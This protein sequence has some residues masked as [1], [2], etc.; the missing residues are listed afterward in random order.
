MFQLFDPFR[1]YDANRQ[2]YSFTVERHTETDNLHAGVR[3]RFAD[4]H[5]PDGGIDNSVLGFSL[6]SV[7]NR[8]ILHT[9]RFADG[10]FETAFCVTF[11]KE[12]DPEFTVYVRYD[13]TTRTGEGVRLH[14]GLNGVLTAS[15]V[16][17]QGSSAE[18]MDTQST[19]FALTDSEF[20]PLSITI[21]PEQVSCRV[22]GAEFVFS[23]TK[24]R[25]RLAIERGNFIGELILKQIGF[26]SPEEFASRSILPATTAEIPMIN[27]GSIPYRFT[28]Q[29]DEI[30]GE[31]YLRCGLDGGTKTR[32]VNK[33]N[34][35]GQYV[36]EIDWMDDPYVGICTGGKDQRFELSLG[37][38]GFVDPNNYWDCLAPY[39]GDTELP[40]EGC[41]R[42]NMPH[43]DE[44]SAILFG[45][46]KLRC[47]NY[48]AQ[49]G[50]REFRFAPDGR[51]LYH[52]EAPDGRDI[53]NLY[54]PFD[55]YAVTAI[56]ADCCR[57]VEVVEHFKYNHYFEISE[58]IRFT[59]EFATT[60]DSD[61]FSA[62]AVLWNAYETEKLAQCITDLT[63][64]CR[65]FDRFPCVNGYHV[66][67]ADAAF[68]PLPVGVY[69]VEF[70]ILYGG[71]EYHRVSH[72]FEVFD[73]N[74]E[75][76]PA[77]A[78]GLP[79]VFS[80]PNEH[81]WLEHNSF[82]PWSPARS[83]DVEHYIACVTDTP[84]E[85]EA[86]RT[87]E[88][89]PMFKREWFAWVGPRTCNDFRSER[90]H[91][92][93]QHA[94]YTYY[95]MDSGIE[96][97]LGACSIFPFRPDLWE[98]SRMRN[99]F[100]KK[101]LKEFFAAHPEAAETLDYT[102]SDKTMP[103]DVFDR[104]MSR[105][106]QEWKALVVERTT[107]IF[108]T[109]NQELAALNPRIR[110]AMYGPVSTYVTPNLT[111]KTLP[112]FGLPCD[113]RLTDTVYTG[114]AILEDYP[115]SCSYQ[116]WRGAFLL[117]TLLPHT[118][119]L[120]IYPE[121]YSGGMGG[122][123]DGAVKFAHAPMGKYDL[124]AH[125]N[126]SHAY[127]FVYNTAHLTADGFRYWDTY[128][129]HRSD[130]SSAYM[131][132][133]GAAWGHVVRSKPV[134][135]LRTMAFAVD[136]A[137][138]DDVFRSFALD[139]GRRHVMYNIS[140]AGCGLLHECSRT[141]GLPNG[142]G[143]R[144]RDFA[145]LNRDNCDILVLPS[146][147]DAAPETLEE[148]RRLYHAGVN[149]VAV[150][151]VSGLEDLFGVKSCPAHAR[152]TE[153]HCNEKTEYVYNM[154]ADFR[155]A[156]CSAQ[157]LLTSNNGLPAVLATER[158]LLINTD[159][160]NLGCEDIG[161]TCVCSAP[162]F[163]GELLPQLLQQELNRL[164]RPLAQGGD[165]TGVT[166]FETA[167]GRT[168]LMVTDYAPFD[169]IP[170]T[171]REVAVRLNLDVADVRSDRPLF[172]GRKNGTVRE[173]RLR[174]KSHETA[175]VELKLK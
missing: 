99:P 24:G 155:Y 76:N 165:R 98:Y 13:E 72:T 167:D 57:R 170:R 59:L 37:T 74:S 39:F 4:G 92:V 26:V 101:L 148:I 95:G 31:Y 97:W 121:Q 2:P 53:C 173:I 20:V 84:I 83:C 174:L 152:V 164:S 105:Y 107:D 169:N 133:E 62:E 158:T 108:R 109:Q 162:H 131:R 171:E 43:V 136:Y 77:L 144:M 12:I 23:L 52:G 11:L 71:Q 137:D 159:V 47:R 147:A 128:G 69:Q 8:H 130:R 58:Q 146:L 163:V 30:D 21:A 106:H 66:L 51:L 117:M 118:P 42:L 81:K 91:I 149:L 16:R 36:A 14:F 102:P 29:L 10:L 140:E 119:G 114:F 40:L 126:A 161:K 54:S 85:A 156:P 79:Y 15:L 88:L 70:R 160:N 123:I 3:P 145:L 175:F 50:A 168:E 68:A 1:S 86:R 90:H 27:G 139:T 32:P 166:L 138:S 134:R 73:R 56:P 143:V 122:C 64:G 112:L 48:S 19:A 25:G 150:S 63:E 17:L 96:D 103:V 65:E 110:R 34:R 22:G 5:S 142:F 6:K 135:P 28:W 153:I 46:R 44:V 111:A 157:V 78:S 115:Y 35:R 9:P 104:F 18:T 60:K 41:F 61:Y 113:E 100:Q 93:L 94:D 127:E 151:D 120:R 49:M 55:K 141:A 80:M 132:Q 33:S 75:Q 7:G 116:P 125:Q 172:I 89:L 82:D 45:Y 154:D 129:F 124:P 87:W 38:N 67:W